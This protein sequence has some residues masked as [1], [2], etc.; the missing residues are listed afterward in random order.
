H[1]CRCGALDGESLQSGRSFVCFVRIHAIDRH[2]TVETE[3]L[4]ASCAHRSWDLPD[5]AVTPE[6]F[7]LQRR[8]FLRVFG[9]GLAASAFLP[10]TIRAESIASSDSFNPGF[11]L[12][13]IKLTPEDLVT[14]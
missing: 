1:S 3:T 7:Y 11:K 12:D 5:S 8:E 9:L 6:A 2:M 14:G 13:G 4:R 10:P